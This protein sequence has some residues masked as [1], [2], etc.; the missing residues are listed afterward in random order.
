VKGRDTFA[1]PVLNLIADFLDVFA[2][3][4]LPDAILA[5]WL[6]NR[7]GEDAYAGSFHNDARGREGELE[8]I[9]MTDYWGHLNGLPSMH[10]TG[11]TVK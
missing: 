9:R 10:W 6:S 2:R 1:R 11:L 7:D 3:T 5:A 8:N 4:Y